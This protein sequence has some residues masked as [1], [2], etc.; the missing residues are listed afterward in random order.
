MTRAVCST[1]NERDAAYTLAN[2]LE[3]AMRGD[4]P[5]ISHVRQDGTVVHMDRGTAQRLVDHLRL[6]AARWIA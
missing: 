5:L 3:R 4:T 6:K 1:E 2:R